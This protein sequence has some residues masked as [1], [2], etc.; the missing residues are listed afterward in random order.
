M[1]RILVVETL[2]DNKVG[3]DDGRVNCA[4]VAAMA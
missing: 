2:M 4:L 3:S 1:G